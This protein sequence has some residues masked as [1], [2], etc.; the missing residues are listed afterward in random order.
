MLRIPLAAALPDDLVS[1]PVDDGFTIEFR[2]EPTGQ[3]S[4]VR[5]GVR[6]LVAY[7]TAAEIAAVTSPTGEV[8]LIQRLAPP[9]A[10]DREPVKHPHGWAITRLGGGDMHFFRR[11]KSLC[12]AVIGYAGLCYPTY[13]QSYFPGAMPLCERCRTQLELEG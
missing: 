1:V 4:F 13:R 3:S 7:A 11:T 12:G 2:V 9:G 8:D 6:Y 10:P 5:G